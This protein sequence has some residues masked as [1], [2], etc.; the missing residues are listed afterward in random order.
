[1]AMELVNKKDEAIKK[2]INRKFTKTQVVLKPFFLAEGGMDVYHKS[3]IAVLKVIV[4]LVYIPIVL[5]AGVAEAVEVGFLAGC[6]KVVSMYE[7]F[8]K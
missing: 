7:G 6:K 2:K 8:L 5:I 4:G 3:F 1:M